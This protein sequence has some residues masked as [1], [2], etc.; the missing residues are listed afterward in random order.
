MADLNGG[1]DVDL[2]YTYAE[3][4]ASATFSV[5]VTDDGGAS[6]SSSQSITVADAP[7]TGS[8]TAVAG[9]T[10]N[11]ANSSVLSGAT[12]TDANP[13]NQTADMTATITWGDNGP[14]SLGTVSYNAGSGVY[15]VGGSH[16]YAEE[17]N[18]GI[19]IAVV[20]QGGSTTTI[21]GT[22]TV[23]DAALSASGVA[24]SAVEGAAVSNVKVA[25]FTDAD[26]AGTATDYVAAI[27]WGDSDTTASYSI[28]AANGG[29]FDV[30]A[31]KS[32]AYAE[33][34]T[35][36]ISVIRLPR[37]PPVPWRRLG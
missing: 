5:T 1:Y 24:V 4:L 18:Y 12:F 3:A 29:G 6:T 7:L 32:N 23:Q 2:S 26:P 10:E 17:G 21:T 31:G 16:T 28:V 27:N 11:A 35:Y 20:D 13:G 34:G 19:S 33:E 25:H 36:A 8:T 9:G 37:F 30:I 22:A 14:T 15:T